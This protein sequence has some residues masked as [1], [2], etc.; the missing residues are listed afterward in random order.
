[1]NTFKNKLGVSFEVYDAI[2]YPDKPQ[3]FGKSVF[4]V[5]WYMLW[6]GSENKNALPLPSRFQEVFALIRSS[7]HPG[8]IVIDIEHWDVHVSTTYRTLLKTIMQMFKAE[9]PNHQI[10]NYAICPKPN[11]AA[12]FVA[13]DNTVFYTWRYDNNQVIELAD[14]SDNLHPTLY[15]RHQT[16]REWEQYAVAHLLEAQRYTSPKKIIPFIMPIYHDQNTRRR[17]Q[18]IDKDFWKLQ[19]MTCLRMCDGV[20]VWLET[21]PAWLEVYPHLQWD[22]TAPWYKTTLDFIQDYAS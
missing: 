20:I 2:V 22:R 1:M 4:I 8:P 18:Y 19:L 11:L 21:T 15:T 16:P 3:P 5:Y 12:P 6:K 13:T 10:G 17:L 9:F 14:L 7:Q